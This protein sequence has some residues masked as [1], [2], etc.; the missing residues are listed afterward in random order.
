[1][2]KE[3]SAPDDFDKK[4]AETMESSGIDVYANVTPSTVMPYCQC[5]FNQPASCIFANPSGVPCMFSGCNFNTT[6]ACGM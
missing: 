6:G 3:N 2:I 1:M 5:S 4:F